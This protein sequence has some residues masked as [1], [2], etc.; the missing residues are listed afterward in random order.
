MPK[1]ITHFALARSFGRH[2]PETSLFFSPITQYPNLFCLGAVVPDIPFFYLAGPYRKKIQIL[3]N[4]FHSADAS[5]L[6]PVLRFLGAF[7]SPAALALA[8][9][10]IYHLV[11]DTRFHPMVYYYAGMDNVHQGATGRHRQFETAMDLHFHYLYGGDASLYHLVRSV[12]IPGRVL[13][14]Y[15]KALFRA[16]GLPPRTLCLARLWHASLQYLFRARAMRRFVAWD[17]QHARVLPDR[18]SGVVYPFGRAVRLPFFSGIV[19]YR[20]PYTGAPIE[21]TIT[22]MAAQT[23][24][25]GVT[26]LERVAGI[27][28]SVPGATDRDLAGM[29]LQDPALSQVRPDLD[30]DRFTHWRGKGNLL[31]DLYRGT[32]LYICSGQPDP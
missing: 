26:V 1:E 21:T 25:S 15:L 12:E 24:S 5:A 22:D 14:R 6:V 23:I 32:A 16:D 27:I 7:G 13:D 19:Q 2:L 8:A 9:G 17:R 28:R 18:V 30:P 31:A 29:V 10:V 4:P 20:D 11:S 3:S